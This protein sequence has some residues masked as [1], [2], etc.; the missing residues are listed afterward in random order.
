MLVYNEIR[1]TNAQYFAKYCYISDL[2]RIVRMFERHLDATIGRD[3][4]RSEKEQEYDAWLGEL[5][6][7]NEWD[8]SKTKTDNEHWW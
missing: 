7:S 3:T 8:Y 2:P 6:D 1:L 5:F 4:T